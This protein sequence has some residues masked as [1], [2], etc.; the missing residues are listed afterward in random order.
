MQFLILAHYRRLR[1][2]GFCQQS[3]GFGN[4]RTGKVELENG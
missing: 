1:H 2:Y 4:Q 3:R